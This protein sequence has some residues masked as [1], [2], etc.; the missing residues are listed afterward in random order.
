MTRLSA[1]R[2]G[3]TA[4]FCGLLWLAVHGCGPNSQQGPFL[5][6]PPAVGTVEPFIVGI[7][8]NSQ[9]D[10]DLGITTNP[11][12]GQTGHLILPPG[13]HA[14]F[15]VGFLPSWVL[16]HGVHTTATPPYYFPDRF[17]QIDKDY[18]HYATSI[19]LGFPYP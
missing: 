11:V 7:Q 6:N 5:T 14:D 16:V 17:F 8:N 15:D 9:W 10:I 3:A 18:S 13:A 2:R 4:L 12:T 1:T 19:S